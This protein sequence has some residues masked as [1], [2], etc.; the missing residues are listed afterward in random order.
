MPLIGRPSDENSIF[1]TPQERGRKI[2]IMQ[3]HQEQDME[4]VRVVDPLDYPEVF[5]GD[6]G[7]A[8]P[9]LTEWDAYRAEGIV[10]MKEALLTARDALEAAEAWS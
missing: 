5:T 1:D 3:E 7:P 10:T 2:R 9:V 8:D 4:S 6:P